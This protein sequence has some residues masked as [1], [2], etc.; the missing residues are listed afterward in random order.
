[1]FSIARY[2][3]K[4]NEYPTYKGAEVLSLRPVVA[5][6]NRILARGK[7]SWALGLKP[8]ILAPWEAEIGRIIVQGQP[9]QKVYESPS[10]QKK[11]RG[12]ATYLSSQLQEKV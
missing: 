12:S 1:L 6:L 5:C 9:G 2:K 11:P 8:I 3:S 10:Q 4:C 7:H